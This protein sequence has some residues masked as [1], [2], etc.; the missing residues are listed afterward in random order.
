MYP[1]PSP[2]SLFL[3]FFICAATLTIVAGV[4]IGEEFVEEKS[5]PLFSL[6]NPQEGT[7]ASD[8]SSKCAGGLCIKLSIPRP[9]SS[10]RKR[11]YRLVSGTGIAKRPRSTNEKL[12]S[13]FR[14][15]WQNKAFA[16]GSM[17]QIAI[18]YHNRI[19]SGAFGEVYTGKSLVNGETVA[20]KIMSIVK[21][22]HARGYFN[23][24]QAIDFIA[25][26]A[27]VSKLAHHR[28]VIKCGGVAIDDDEGEAFLPCEFCARGD[29]I[30]VVNNFQSSPLFGK[31]Q[32]QCLFSQ[33]MYGLDHLHQ[34]HIAHRDI[35]LDNLFLTGDGILKIGD[36]AT[37]VV[38]T[39]SDPWIPLNKLDGT[40]SYWSPEIFK[41]LI[42]RRESQFSSASSNSRKS[43]SLLTTTATDRDRGEDSSVS[44]ETST[45]AS[46]NPASPL[47]YNPFA[48]DIWA[49]ATVYL[50]LRM[51][52]LAWG[53]TSL[54][55]SDKYKKYLE[56][57]ASFLIGSLALDMEEYLFIQALLEADVSKRLTARQVVEHP[58]F[59][60]MPKTCANIALD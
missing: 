48:S 5:T 7:A 51:R 34:R 42:Q 60:S 2:I 30:T 46:S 59:H 49:A 16:P 52:T 4:K 8:S 44:T 18:D 14:T 33:I 50:S 58:Y 9:L 29:L 6:I 17:D 10:S 37:S 13:Y 57:P 15:L 21:V 23:E 41:L 24:D 40:R 11:K 1:R 26:E 54:P 20:V 12:I 3:F 53:D 27:S 56:D 38:Q 22:Q 39:L 36:M 25:H 31:E 19:G 35:K 43:S 32:T 55:R 45:P 47:Q 28:N